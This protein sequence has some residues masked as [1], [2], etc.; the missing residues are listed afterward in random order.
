MRQLLSS[1][2]WS[3]SRRPWISVSTIKVFA[4]WCNICFNAYSFSMSIATLGFVI[5]FLESLEIFFAVMMKDWIEITNSYFTNET[6]SHRSVGHKKKKSVFLK[7]MKILEVY[8]PSGPDFLLAAWVKP[9]LTSHRPLYLTWR[10]GIIYLLNVACSCHDPWVRNYAKL[11]NVV[12]KTIKNYLVVGCDNKLRLFSSR[13]F[14][15]CLPEYL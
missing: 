13:K 5:S 3:L 9:C 12:W 7:N 10:N 15:P 2:L 11:F 8:G 1:S 14:L 4:V 6:I